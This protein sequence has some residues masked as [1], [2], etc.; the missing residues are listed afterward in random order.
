MTEAVSDSSSSRAPTI[1]M[2]AITSTPAWPLSRSRTIEMT[3]H[4]PTSTAGTVQHHHA[5]SSLPGDRGGQADDE[6]QHGERQHQALGDGVERREGSGHGLDRTG[7]ACAPAVP[8][9][10]VRRPR[11]PAVAGTVPVRRDGRP[12][13]SSAQ[14]PTPGHTRSTPASW[15]ASGD[16]VVPT[17]TNEAPAA[18]VISRSTMR[19]AH[20]HGVGSGHA[21]VV[22]RPDQCLG[23]G[24]GALDVVRVPRRLEHAGQVETLDVGLH[25]AAGGR[26]DEADLHAMA[27]Q[28]AERTTGPGHRAG[29]HAGHLGRPP[30]GHLVPE[31]LRD[32]ELLVAAP[33]VGRVLLAEPL[34]AHRQAVVAQRGHVGAVDHRHR[35]DERAVPVE[36]GGGGKAACGHAPIVWEAQRSVGRRRVDPPLS[37][38][39][40]WRSR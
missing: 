3:S 25:D 6:A 7:R 9:G 15:N 24:L 8:V 34:P 23:V 36:D 32:P 20:V 21:E 33:P 14:A 40:R 27:A 16:I 28:V 1:A 37:P 4:T 30:A 12:S 38:R 31:V 35:V 29:P 5:S 18:T 19:V 17:A 11:G 13:R 26:R 2:T 10:P 39:G 22:E